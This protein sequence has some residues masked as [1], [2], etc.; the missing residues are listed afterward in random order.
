MDK[1]KQVKWRTNEL[2]KVKGT[3]VYLMCWKLTFGI[4][5]NVLRLDI[6]SISESTAIINPPMQLNNYLTNSVGIMYLKILD[7]A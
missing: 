4:T 7:I 6:L 1:S 3:F 2:P 5:L